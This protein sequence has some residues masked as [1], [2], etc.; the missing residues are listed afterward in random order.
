MPALHFRGSPSRLTFAAHLRCSPSLL[1]FAAHLRC[2]AKLCTNAPAA[3]LVL[4]TSMQEH[5]H[6]FVPYQIEDLVCN[7]ERCAGLCKTG[8]DAGAC[9]DPYRVK[10]T[11]LPYSCYAPVRAT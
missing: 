5:A 9:L 4:R 10:R 11:G 7:F 8:S 1:T 6:S 2:S 3:L